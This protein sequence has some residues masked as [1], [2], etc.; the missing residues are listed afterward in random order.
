MATKVQELDVVTIT[1]FCIYCGGLLL[2]FIKRK[3]CAT[4]IQSVRFLTDISSKNIW[5]TVM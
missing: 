1:V 5:R 2:Y 4:N 3:T